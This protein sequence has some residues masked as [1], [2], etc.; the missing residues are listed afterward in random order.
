MDLVFMPLS[1]RRRL[2]STVT[3]IHPSRRARAPEAPG[4]PPRSSSAS[5][6][7]PAPRATLPSRAVGGHGRVCAEAAHANGRRLVDV[8]VPVQSWLRIIGGH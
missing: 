1:V 3:H 7:H 6:H 5:S 4:E 8:D 2:P